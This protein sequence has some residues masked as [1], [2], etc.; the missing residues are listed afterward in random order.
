MWKWGVEIWSVD[1]EINNKVINKVNKIRKIK[2]GNE[3]WKNKM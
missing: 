1:K 3:I 2:Y